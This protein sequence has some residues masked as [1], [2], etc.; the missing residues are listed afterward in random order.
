MSEI[1]HS[2][3]RDSLLGKSEFDEQTVPRSHILTTV[4]NAYSKY[5]AWFCHVHFVIDE[6]ASDS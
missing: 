5:T 3:R 1:A 2:T 6:Q 4:A